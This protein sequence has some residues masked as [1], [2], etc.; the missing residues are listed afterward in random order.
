MSDPIDYPPAFT[1]D[2]LRNLA[3]VLVRAR[4][5]ALSGHDEDAGET[6]WSLGSSTFERACKLFMLLSM[7]VP[8]LRYEKRGFVFIL[9]V[10]GIPLK[11]HRCDPEKPSPRTMR[12]LPLESLIKDE[13][14]QLA[15]EFGEAGEEAPLAAG[16]IEYIWRLYYESDPETNEVFRV[17]LARIVGGTAER[18]WDIDLSEPVVAIAPVGG[19]LPEAQELDSPMV[20]PLEPAALREGTDAE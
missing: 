12:E 9:V 16:A 19:E 20:A 2:R 17:A 13:V 11:F 18:T 1:P 6:N 5:G 14:R 3:D 10:E 8:W 15:F 7:K 4:L